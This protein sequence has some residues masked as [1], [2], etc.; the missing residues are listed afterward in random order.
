MEAYCGMKLDLVTGNRE[1]VKVPSLLQ[2]LPARLLFRNA[3]IQRPRG[4]G[5]C[6]FGGRGSGQSI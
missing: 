4:E 1:K 3:W 2:P 6:T 5:K